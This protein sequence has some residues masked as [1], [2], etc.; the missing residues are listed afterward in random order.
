[1]VESF[2]FI[3]L[4]LCVGGLS[5]FGFWVLS[6]DEKIAYAGTFAILAVM[7]CVYRFI[8]RND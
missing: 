2:E 5:A 6:G 8:I 7:Y 1:M 3:L 4:W